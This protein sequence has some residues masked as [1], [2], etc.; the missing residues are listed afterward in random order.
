MPY[1]YVLYEKKNHIGYVTL[2]RP[3]VLNAMH[4]DMHRELNEIFDDFAEDRDMWVAIFT[5]AGDRAFS[6]GN[7]LKITAASSASG[8]QQRAP[9]FGGKG[10]FGGITA[11]YD[12]FKP[13]ICAVNGWCVGGGFETALACDLII[14]A[15]HARFGLPEPKR[16]L[17][18]GVGGVHRLVRQA[19]LK[20]AMGMLLTGDPID[21]QEA[22]DLGLVN[23]VVPLDDLIPAAERWAE[24]IMACAPLAVRGCKEAAMIGLEL[25]LETAIIRPYTNVQALQASEDSKEGP[26]AFAEKREPVWTGG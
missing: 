25:P 9:G 7:D 16:G 13:I 12:L 3:E 20:R 19:P 14:A 21:A 23:E 17:V 22:Y 6:A 10:G 5:G 24:R 2:N 1:E 11:R 15:D 18:A 26:R 8:G 4:A